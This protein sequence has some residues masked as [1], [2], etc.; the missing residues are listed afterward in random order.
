MKRERSITKRRGPE[1]RGM[2][3]GIC[4]TPIT[5]RKSEE[6]EGTVKR[7]TK[8]RGG[9]SKRLVPRSPFPSPCP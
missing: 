4:L 8:M 7:K 3:R 2:R 6:V 9:G 1:Q 5:F